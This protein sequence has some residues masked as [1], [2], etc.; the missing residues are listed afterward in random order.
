[1][2]KDLALKELNKRLSQ[3]KKELEEKNAI[4]EERIKKLDE[5]DTTIKEYESQISQVEEK[6]NKLLQRENEILSNYVHKYDYLLEMGD[7]TYELVTK[8]DIKMAS[9]ECIEKFTMMKARDIA[10]VQLRFCE[11]EKEK[12]E[13]LKDKDFNPFEEL[14]DYRIDGVIRF[15]TKRE[16]LVANLKWD[17]PIDDV[18]KLKDMYVSKES[19]W[20]EPKQEDGEY[21]YMALVWGDDVDR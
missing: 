10:L 5:L 16:E 7:G 17:I 4:Y 20:I 8:D 3:R 15:Y 2:I 12:Y 21:S 18:V 1:M 11:I 6:F 19:F 9:K 13:E 14:I